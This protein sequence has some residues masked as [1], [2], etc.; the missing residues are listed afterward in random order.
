VAPG[1]RVLTIGKDLDA[2]FV[3]GVLDR[4]PAQRVTARSGAY[5]EVTE[6]REGET[7]RVYS[8]RGDLLVEI[9]PATDQA[10]ITVPTA[11]LHL[12]APQGDVQIAAGHA[13]RM[14][15]GAIDLRAVQSVQARAGGI[16][17][18]TEPS[19][20]SVDA[21]GARIEGRQLKLDAERGQANIGELRYSGK[22]AHLTA[23]TVRMAVDSLETVA[24]T[25]IQSAQNLYTT[26]K[27]LAQLRAGRIRQRADETCH[28]KAGQVYLHAEQEFKVQGEKIHLG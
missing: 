20:L 15:A 9:D 26:V 19:T 1:D 6:A 11:N 13:I 22:A 10:R 14:A 24:E 25:V 23:K 16:A 7:L 28:L 21:E 3:I 12:A 2:L 17:A 27:Q 4:M 18:G 8:S 5:A